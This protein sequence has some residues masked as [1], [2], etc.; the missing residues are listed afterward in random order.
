MTTQH[1]L[2]AIKVALIPAYRSTDFEVHRNWLAITSSLP[3]QDWYVAEGSEWTLDYPPLF[4]WLES[5]LAQLA[6]LCDPA[7]LQVTNNGYASPATV[8]F[9]RT[10]VMLTDFVLI[11]AAWFTSRKMPAAQSLAVFTL[12]VAHPALLIVDHIHFQYNGLLLGILVWSIALIKEEHC[13]LGAFLFAV[14]V[15]M[16]HLFASLG[17]L[18]LIYLLRHYCRGQHAVQRF[19]SLGIIV[20]A[21]CAVSFGPFIAHGQI[22]QVLER[23]FPFGRGL[24][25]AYWAA[26]VWALYTLAD[27]VLARLLHKTAGLASSTGG[28][29]QTFSFAVLPDIGPTT[30]A[31]LSLAAMV[32]VLVLTFRKP[33]PRS[34]PQAI[35]LMAL[36]SFMLGYHV[37]EK[38]VLTVLIPLAMAAGDSIEAAREFMFVSLV[39]TY[40][41]FPLLFTW[42]E[43]PIKV[44]LFVTYHLL[45]A[46]LLYQVLQLPTVLHPVIFGASRLQFLP[47]LLTSTVS[48]AGMLA[49][50]RHMGRSLLGD[51]SQSKVD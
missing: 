17:P 21:V 11:S 23:L 16:K 6:K 35:A 31:V 26:N 42:Q 29:V 36:C 44:A 24:N 1:N 33:E 22:K 10:S 47:L 5:G 8:L 51:F 45:A 46:L 34:F 9:Q 27:K 2:P 43:Y 39:G 50:W 32:P 28:L 19:L 20:L 3:W 4:A 13:L 37:H 25:H 18:Y 15:N 7:M 41:L 30:C 14:L 40:A 49:A 38:A 48:A 12:I